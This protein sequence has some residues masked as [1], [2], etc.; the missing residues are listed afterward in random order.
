[1][2]SLIENGN[3]RTGIFRDPITLIRPKEFVL[4][5]PLGSVRGALARKFA[6]KQFHYM[7]GISDSL[8]FGAAIVDLRYLS[9]VFYYVY[10]LKTGR[11]L[12]NT[13]RKPFSGSVRF[14]ENPESGSVVFGSGKNTARV[15]VENGNRM[16]EVISNGKSIIAAAF[17]DAEA[18]IEPLRICTRAGYTGWVYVR[19]T[20]G[21]PLS[22]VVDC[23]LGR[24]DLKGCLGHTDYSVGYMRPETWW[25]WAFA[26]GKINGK[27]FAMN[28]SCGVNETS[29][30]E[31]CY[32]LDGKLHSLPL[33]RFD[34]DQKNP[35]GPWKVSS[36]M[37]NDFSLDFAARG[38]H[39]EH[40]NA[41]K[42]ASRFSQMYGSFEGQI[43]LNGKKIS[44]KNLLGFTEDHYA[45]W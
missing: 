27:T 32:W 25:N 41:G 39:K 28:V 42:I 12:R 18:K 6:Y 10:D 22:G 7:G 8:I 9:T 11:E 15:H 45:K 14:S 5:K 43:V 34:F 19:K 13:W 29:Y 24:F 37:N 44:V 1:M 30:T 36:S 35:M 2:S 3:V 21:V 26:S 31:N 23:D 33:A 16:L 38:Q 17:P 20:G 4:R 40:V